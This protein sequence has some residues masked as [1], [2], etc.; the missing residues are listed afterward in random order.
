[1]D[2]RFTMTTRLIAIA[3]I[4]FLLLLALL[5]ALGFQLGQQWGT[6]EAVTRYQA[7]QLALPN[8]PALSAPLAAPALNPPA[9]AP[10][11]PALAG[12]PAPPATVTVAPR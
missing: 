6:E 5:F 9:L 3:V 1:M 7:T 11:A 2:Y 12:T 8:P 10:G 4:S